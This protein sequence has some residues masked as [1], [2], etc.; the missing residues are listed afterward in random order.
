MR[1]F[2]TPVPHVQIAH[3]NPEGYP[4]ES[5]KTT[6]STPRNLANNID[7][8]DVDDSLHETNYQRRWFI[9]L[10]FARDAVPVGQS[11]NLTDNIQNFQ[12]MINNFAQTRG[13][14]KKQIQTEYCKKKDLDKYLPAN[15]KNLIK[16]RPKTKRIPNDGVSRGG[17]KT[18][19]NSNSASAIIAT[20]TENG[21]N[22]TT[23]AISS[24]NNNN[25]NPTSQQPITSNPEKHKTGLTG[26]EANMHDSK[27]RKM[28]NE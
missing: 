19:P 18:I 24:I 13:G 7:A 14:I 17:E 22:L 8:H 6:S 3:A 23:E 10:R 28:T 12:D 15:K 20:A 1:F 16:K 27:R 2:Q 25:N 11:I 4:L 9:G 5:T 21:K 26:D